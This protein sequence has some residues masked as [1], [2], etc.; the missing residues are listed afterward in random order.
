L[1]TTSLPMSLPFLDVVAWSGDL[2]AGMKGIAN[3]TKAQV[4]AQLLGRTSS[5]GPQQY[6]QTLALST[7]SVEV[8]ETV[9]GYSEGLSFI[10][11]CQVFHIC[12]SSPLPG[13][14]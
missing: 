2:N 4:S 8:C 7:E 9:E 12:Q 5:K 11:S 3:C 10:A 1:A 14:T 13:K 6:H